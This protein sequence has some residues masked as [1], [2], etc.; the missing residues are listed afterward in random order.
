M[1]GNRFNLDKDLPISNE[2][3]REL[4]R[5]EIFLNNTLFFQI[6]VTDDEI[7]ELFDS[8]PNFAL[9]GKGNVVPLEEL[10]KEIKGSIEIKKRDDALK[11]Y[12]LSLYNVY[13]SE[14]KPTSPAIEHQYR[15]LPIIAPWH[16][17]VITNCFTFTGGVSESCVV[18]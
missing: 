1:Y 3:I 15:S 12:L 17:D 2:K 4:I 10:R 8:E 16:P 7:S 9:D 6:E 14:F 11:E 5:I 18:S 13:A